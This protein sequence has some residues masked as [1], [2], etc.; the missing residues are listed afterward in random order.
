MSW[1]NDLSTHRSALTDGLEDAYRLTP[2]FAPARERRP[3]SEPHECT[4][5]TGTGG[6]RL[7]SGITSDETPWGISTAQSDAQSLW[8]KSTSDQSSL[9]ECSSNWGSQLPQHTSASPSQRSADAFVSS[10]LLSV[11]GMLGEVVR[12]LSGANSRSSFNEC[13]SLLTAAANDASAVKANATGLQGAGAEGG[14]GGGRSEE[15]RLDGAATGKEAADNEDEDDIVLL[16]DDADLGTISSLIASLQ[17]HSAQVGIKEEEADTLQCNQDE[18][19]HHGSPTAIQALP[20][21]SPVILDSPSTAAGRQPH[22]RSVFVDPVPRSYERELNHSRGGNAPSSPFVAITDAGGDGNDHRNDF[23]GS[24]FTPAGAKSTSHEATMAPLH[25]TPSTLEGLIANFQTALRV[26]SGE[27]SAS[28]LAPQMPD[29][30]LLHQDRYGSPDTQDELGIVNSMS[31]AGKHAAEEVSVARRGS[32][33]VRC[34]I[35]S[36]VAHK[37]STD[38]NLRGTPAQ[39]PRQGVRVTSGMNSGCSDSSAIIPQRDTPIAGRRVSSHHHRNPGHAPHER[40]GSP[41]SSIDCFFSQTAP[42]VTAFSP[43]LRFASNST[44]EESATPHQST[45]V[46]SEISLPAAAFTY[47]GSGALHQHV[48]ERGCITVVDPQ[49]RKLHVPIS[50]VQITKALNGRLKTPSLCLLFQ[51][52][53]CRQGDNCYQVHI[54]PATVDRLRADVESMPCCCLLHGDCNCHLMDPAAYEGHSLC[55]SGQYN[56]PLSRVAYTAGLQRVLQEEATSVLVSPSVLCRL[57]GQPGG[58]RFGADCKFIHVCCRIL[59]SEL[60]QVISSATTAATVPTNAPSTQAPSQQQHPLPPQRLESSAPGSPSTFVHSH[61]LSNPMS[62]SVSNCNSSPTTVVPRQRMVMP[63]GVPGPMMGEQS[64]SPL[65]SMQSTRPLPSSGSPM[66]KELRQSS[67]SQLMGSS[68][69]GSNGVALYNRNVVSTPRQN[70]CSNNNNS[71]NSLVS[72]ANFSPMQL[73]QG[74]APPLSIAY[75]NAGGLAS[76]APA[77]FTN[78]APLQS[79][80]PA[81]LFTFTT[82]QQPRNSSPQS[83]GQQ[84]RHH[85]QQ[86]VSQQ[87]YLQQF[88]Q[89]GTVSLVPVNMVPNLSG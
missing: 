46:E 9:P 87:F 88:N 20:P 50:A 81:P 40:S 5:N 65:S 23:C 13:G 28:A 57:H 35:S 3:A 14:R 84:Q 49:R 86:S 30:E 8:Q 72:S 67:S 47:N 37:L 21:T 53:R 15:D 19:K 78:G 73:S 33:F 80:L 56:V 34:H 17:D 24:P 70:C 16:Y 68:G 11:K 42:P 62:L 41:D 52:G 61:T 83:Q 63:A 59:I 29:T 77:V 26:R 31:E 18:P 22:P 10:T 6:F 85:H 66:L 38:S 2:T 75:N 25:L 89:D 1:W 82:V 55:I 51:S 48:D 76:S 60:A 58:C 69:T 74:P 27:M 32:P 44:M 12:P 7:K 64:L 4:G 36:V 79:Q 39:D 54:D 45:R 71:S 43:V